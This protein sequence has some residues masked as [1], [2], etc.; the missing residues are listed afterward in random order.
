MPQHY[1]WRGQTLELLLHVQPGAS[2]AG[3][4]GLHGERLKL[5]IDAPATDDRAN[6]AV[7]AFLAEAFGVRRAAVELVSGRSSRRKSFAIAS[8]SRLPADAL[9][10][11]A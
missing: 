3:F 4:A 9:V 11:P 7:T 2:S 10:A 6:R 8:P 5:R 1:R